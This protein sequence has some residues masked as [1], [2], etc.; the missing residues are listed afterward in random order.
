MVLHDEGR[1]REAESQ[2]RQALAIYDKSLPPNHPYRAAASM[3][4][5]RLL[6]DSDR[7]QEALRLSEQSAAIWS[8]N[9]PASHPPAA[10]AHAIHAYAL[11]RL[12]RRREAAD[13]LATAVPILLAA[14]GPDDPAVR[15]AQ[16][17]W[18]SVRAPASPATANAANS[19]PGAPSETGR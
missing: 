8:A 7:P 10:Q 11:S 6:V 14:R 18:A 12:S 2:F 1:L 4:L 17:W 3:H 13:E 5:A 9:F 19:P 16:A 15:R